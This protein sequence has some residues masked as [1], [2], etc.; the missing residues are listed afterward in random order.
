M[1]D[2]SNIFRVLT[3]AAATTTIIIIIPKRAD[4]SCNSPYFTY[5]QPLA[6]SMAVEVSG[7]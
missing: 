1:H 4:G 2:G 6:C 7:N 5:G 3:A